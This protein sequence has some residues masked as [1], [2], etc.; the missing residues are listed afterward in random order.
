MSRSPGEGVFHYGRA[1]A[2][3]ALAG[4]PGLARAAWY[5]GESHNEEHRKRVG[6]RR[7]G[8]WVAGN[9]TNSA[10]GNA[11]ADTGRDGQGDG[12]RY[13]AEEICQTRAC[14]SDQRYM[15]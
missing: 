11:A 1:F 3:T 5:E 14:G 12:A 10:L 4:P 13:V 8:C 2:H 9:V 6:V 7:D 15:R